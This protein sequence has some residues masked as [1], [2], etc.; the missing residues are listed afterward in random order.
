M[1]K[2]NRRPRAMKNET[3]ETL[4]QGF[5]NVFRAISPLGP[6]DPY[7]EAQRLIWVLK[8]HIEVL[9]SALHQAS[10]RRRLLAFLKKQPEPRPDELERWVTQLRA[11]PAMIRTA[12]VQYAAFL[13]KSNK[14]RRTSVAE[15]TARRACADV[16]TLMDQGH[17]QAKALEEVR[18]KYNIQPRTMYRLWSKWQLAGW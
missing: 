8:H 4:I 18:V 5:E 7:E 15:D 9:L 6:A 14:G 10:S 12:M 17:V 16:H 1:T 13:P 11:A 3:C 2:R